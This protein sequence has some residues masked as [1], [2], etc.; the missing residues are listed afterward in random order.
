MAKSNPF[1]RKIIWKLHT[2]IYSDLCTCG[3]K[4][5][6]TKRDLNKGWTR[7]REREIRFYSRSRSVCIRWLLP[8]LDLKHIPH[9]QF[10][11]ASIHTC[12]SL[13]YIFWQLITM[14]SYLECLFGGYPLRSSLNKGIFVRSIS[15][16]AH[17]YNNN[18]E[19]LR[20]WLHKRSYK[21][22]TR[23]AF[24]PSIIFIPMQLKIKNLFPYAHAC[25]IGS[26]S[27]FIISCV[28]DN[29]NG[30]CRMLIAF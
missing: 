19:N 29:W 14:A 6:E 23:K 17:K 7:E 2:I 15:V 20:M 1:A 4:E 27:V 18:L 26:V 22:A 9:A 28:R 8:L 21:W 13:A 24:R 16:S 12:I 30:L 5:I 25:E 11:P 10:T 3:G